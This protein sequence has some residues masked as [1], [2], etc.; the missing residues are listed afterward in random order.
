MHLTGMTELFADSDP[1]TSSSFYDFLIGP[2]LPSAAYPGTIEPAFFQQG[3][4]TE[5]FVSLGDTGLTDVCSWPEITCDPPGCPDG[6]MWSYLFDIRFESSIPIP[7]NGTPSSDLAVTWFLPGGMAID[8][9]AAD[10]PGGDF[11]LHGTLWTAETQ[12]DDAGGFSPLA[13]IQ[14]AGSGRGPVLV[15]QAVGWSLT[16]KERILNVIGDSGNGFERGGHGGGATNGLRLS[17][18]SGNARISYEVR[19]AQDLGI[20]NQAFVGTSLAPLPL[21]G[22]PVLGARL[23]V[24]PDAAFVGTAGASAASLLPV[25]DVCLDSDYVCYTPPIDG[26][27]DFESPSPLSSSGTPLH[28]PIPASAAGFEVYSQGLVL[29]TTTLEAF[30]TNRVRTSLYP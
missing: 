9:P 26:A 10:C 6:S 7:S 17:V 19:A 15:D 28:V 24:A 8:Y 5:I 4:T 1:S 11:D 22:V 12:A 18:G 25:T 21:P 3:L 2:A 27:A 13:G 23:L 16:F 29:H 14:T 20:P 30:T